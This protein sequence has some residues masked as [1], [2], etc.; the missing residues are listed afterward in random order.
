MALE[1]AARSCAFA[2]HA[3]FPR[4][5]RSAW[6]CR[7]PLKSVLLALIATGFSRGGSCVCEHEAYFH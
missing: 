4:L 2:V 3:P 6:T 1:P 7:G 5:R